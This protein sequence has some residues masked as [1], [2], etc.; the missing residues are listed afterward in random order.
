MC[1]VVVR[2]VV[3]AVSVR[4]DCSATVEEEESL[5]LSVLKRLMHKG[6]TGTWD[7]NSP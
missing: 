2:V 7:A 6:I 4:G 1:F 5:G 3:V